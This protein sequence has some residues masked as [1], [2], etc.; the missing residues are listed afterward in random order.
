MCF[1]IQMSF[2]DS[3]VIHSE[4]FHELTQR[5]SNLPLDE[6]NV[7]FNKTVILFEAALRENEIKIS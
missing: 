1:I 3:T 4:A 6:K 2:S 7:S 5:I